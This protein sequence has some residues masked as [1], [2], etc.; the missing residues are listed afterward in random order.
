MK[1]T[2]EI[3]DLL[4]ENGDRLDNIHVNRKLVP[5]IVEETLATFTK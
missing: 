3:F 4:L 5:N 2:A 1:D